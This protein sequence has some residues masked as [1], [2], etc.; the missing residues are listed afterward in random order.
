MRLFNWCEH[1]RCGT[2]LGCYA[3]SNRPLANHLPRL[4]ESARLKPFPNAHESLN[5]NLHDNNSH[6]RDLSCGFLCI[7]DADP[8]LTH[9]DSTKASSLKDAILLRRL[10]KLSMKDKLARCKP[11]SNLRTSPLS[12]QTLWTGNL[13]VHGQSSPTPFPHPFMP[14]RCTS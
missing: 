10:G 14:L 9:Y 6:T 8:A 2:R 1:L 5:G 3:F 12:S 11:L 13:L 7:P 4:P